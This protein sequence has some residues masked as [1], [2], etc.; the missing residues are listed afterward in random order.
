M[1]NPSFP[2]YAAII[3][4]VKKIVAGSQHHHT[5]HIGYSNAD[6]DIFVTI[7]SVDIPC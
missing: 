5:I 3:I 2:L 6:V 1:D 4:C 7:D